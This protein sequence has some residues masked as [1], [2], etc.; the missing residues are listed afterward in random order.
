VVGSLSSAFEDLNLSVLLHGELGQQIFQH[1]HGN[2]ARTAAS[3]Q[4]SLRGQ[5]TH[6]KG[7]KTS[8]TAQSFVHCV[9]GSREL[10]RVQDN[11]IEPLPGG[12]QLVKV[13]ENISLEKRNLI[14]AVELGVRGCKFQ[15]GRGDINAQYAACFCMGRVQGKS[16]GVAKSIENPPA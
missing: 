14:Q 4:D 1:G 6:S 8:I 12:H 3:Y 10:G 16:A 9:T 13:I 15:G 2:Q 11:Q 7:L 5:Q